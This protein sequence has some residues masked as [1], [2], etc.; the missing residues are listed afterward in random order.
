[1]TAPQ[2]LG[3]WDSSVLAS[4]TKSCKLADILLHLV[5]S[6]LV[7]SVYNQVWIVRLPTNDNFGVPNELVTK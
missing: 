5:K 2:E 3:V 7:V 4:P 6:A 1:M